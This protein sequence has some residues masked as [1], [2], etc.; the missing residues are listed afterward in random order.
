M[1]DGSTVDCKTAHSHHDDDD[2]DVDDDDDD[3]DDVVDT[4]HLAA[5]ATSGPCSSN[6]SSTFIRCSSS[7]LFF[8]PML[9]CHFTFSFDTPLN[10][11]S[12]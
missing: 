11:S 6:Y 10:G 2:D 5:L 4:E 9:F 8:D 12:F 3:D 7:F 1:S